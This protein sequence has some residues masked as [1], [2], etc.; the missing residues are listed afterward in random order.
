MPR[1][2]YRESV[3]SRRFRGLDVDV[4]HAGAAR[5]AAKGAFEALDAI[6]VS[7]GDRLHATVGQVANEPAEAFGACLFDRE[8]TEA[9]TL[10]AS[11]DHE[12][13][14]HD[15]RKLPMIA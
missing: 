15:H 7:L 9:D 1:L 11:A 8:P 13:P 14:R 5:A 10:H 12:P 2:P 3:V 6:R 4:P